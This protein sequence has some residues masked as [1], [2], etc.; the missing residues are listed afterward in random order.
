[1]N[2][3]T[4]KYNKIIGVSGKSQGLT[5]KIQEDSGNDCPKINK[6]TQTL[7]KLRYG[8]GNKIPQP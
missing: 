3:T 1:M 7:E 4:I 8:E 6:E 5:T 2:L